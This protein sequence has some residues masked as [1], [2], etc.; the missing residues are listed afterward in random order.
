[1]VIGG[2]RRITIA[3][4]IVINY[5]PDNPSSNATS[6]KSHVETYAAVSSNHGYSCRVT[7]WA[8]TGARRSNRPVD[9]QS[10][11]AVCA[12]SFC[13]SLQRSISPDIDFFTLIVPVRRVV[14]FRE[15]WQR[16]D[17]SAPMVGETDIKRTDIYGIEP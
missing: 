14:D 8:V 3:T 15:L 6:R 16:G 17:E 11:T 2:K 10:G 1:M 7:D 4:L 13:G 5:V 9:R 12:L